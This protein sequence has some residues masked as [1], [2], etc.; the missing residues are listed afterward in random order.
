M[1][2]NVKRYYSFNVLLVWGIILASLLGCSTSDPK[3]NRV[4]KNDNIYKSQSSSLYKKEFSNDPNASENQI[5][6]PKITID[7]YERLGDIEPTLSR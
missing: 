7:G 6:L 2:E 5:I 4:N 1:K 3:V